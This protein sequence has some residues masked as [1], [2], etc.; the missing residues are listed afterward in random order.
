MAER[1][2]I[3]IDV[4]L[5]AD[6][7]GEA[8]EL[9]AYYLIAA[10]ITNAI[11]HARATRIQVRGAKSGGWLRITVSDDGDG[12]ANAAAGSGI[13]GIVD[14]VR[15]IGG[16]ADIDSPPGHGTQVRARIPCA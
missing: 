12:G 4:D 9:T 11:K 14:R 1:Y 10:S 16:E 5:P 15:G 2:P 7:F 6:R 8:A 13:S 3:R